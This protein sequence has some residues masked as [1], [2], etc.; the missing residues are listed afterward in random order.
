MEPVYSPTSTA[1]REAAVNLC[2]QAWRY[3]DDV[4]LTDR[5]VHKFTPDS[6][7]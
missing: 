4:E 3:Q 6:A 1:L 2:E 5:Q 7:K